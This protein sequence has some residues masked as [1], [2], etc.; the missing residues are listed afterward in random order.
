MTKSDDGISGNGVGRARQVSPS[1]DD[2]AEG[3]PARAQMK[4]TSIKGS[5][6]LDALHELVEALD[7]RRPH[8]E[9]AGE[10]QILV[11][12]RRLRVNA[13]KRIAFLRE[14]AAGRIASWR[15]PKRT[16]VKSDPT[17]QADAISGWEDE[18][19]AGAPDQRGREIPST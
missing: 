6:L 19:G 13:I 15:T 10:A 14:R 16:A 3:A 4:Q 7:K 17:D 1:C 2:C 11:D 12:A 5:D 9:R 8:L 18:G